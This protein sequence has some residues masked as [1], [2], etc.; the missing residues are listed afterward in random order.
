MMRIAKVPYKKLALKKRTY[1]RP[2]TR[3]GIA[4]VSMAHKCSGFEI[5]ER[6]LTVK[7][8]RMHAVSEPR[9]ETKDDMSRE[10]AR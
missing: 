10:L 6:V 2:R 5:F 7:Y 3:P 8:E 9:S 4:S 1:E